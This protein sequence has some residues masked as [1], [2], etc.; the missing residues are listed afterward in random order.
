MLNEAIASLG[1]E[2]DKSIAV[3]RQFQPLPDIL[4][5]HG[6][7]FQI[8]TNVLQN[9]WQAMPEGGVLTLSVRLAANDESA[10]EVSIEDSGPG[11]PAALQPQVFEPFFTT[12]Q[13]QGGGVLDSPSVGPWWNAMAE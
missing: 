3:I 11:I 4:L 12:K 1:L 5:N 13:A 8:F 10:A 7:M 9:A 2:D 6:Q